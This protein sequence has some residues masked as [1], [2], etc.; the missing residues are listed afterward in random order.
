MRNAYRIFVGKTKGRVHSENIDV[1][2][3]IILEWILE[4]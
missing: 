3:R 2:G 1:Y 4:K